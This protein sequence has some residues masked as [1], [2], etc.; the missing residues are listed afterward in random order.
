[1]KNMT[2]ILGIAVS[3]FGLGVLIAFFLPEA[4]LVVLEAIVIVTA[5][6]LFLKR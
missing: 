1:M 4:I 5:G 2:K 3:T 6:F